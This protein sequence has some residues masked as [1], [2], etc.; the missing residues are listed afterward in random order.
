MFKNNSKIE[1]Y[2]YLEYGI[3]RILPKTKIIVNDA[4]FFNMD[5]KLVSV[6]YSEFI[7]NHIP[8]ITLFYV[9]NNVYIYDTKK[10]FLPIKKLF[11]NNNVQK[12]LINLRN[13]SKMFLNSSIQN[14]VDLATK[15][16]KNTITE[17]IKN[18]FNIQFERNIKTNLSSTK[19]EDIDEN[20]LNTLILD[21]IWI[22]NIYQKKLTR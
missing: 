19:F 12:V 5:T 16:K 10:F 13:T 1:K 14:S 7:F 22:Y 11:E 17:G 6:F 15:Y 20:T 8:L 21:T 3:N 18:I 2:D 9:K 4:S